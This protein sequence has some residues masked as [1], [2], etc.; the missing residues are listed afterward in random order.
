VEANQGIGTRLK[1]QFMINHSTQPYETDEQYATA[2]YS[3][4]FKVLEGISKR[5]TAN[6]NR[7]RVQSDNLHK[8]FALRKRVENRTS[9]FEYSE[10]GDYSPASMGEFVSAVPQRMPVN[11]SNQNAIQRVPMQDQLMRPP[12]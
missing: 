6:Y 12:S 8:E 3:E 4:I 2:T 11:M 5:M 1:E 10:E 9:P 7:H